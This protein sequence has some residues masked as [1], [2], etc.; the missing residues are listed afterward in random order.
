M[1]GLKINIVISI[2]LLLFI[3][4]LLTTFVITIFWQRDLTYAEVQRLSTVLKFVEQVSDKHETAVLNGFDSGKYNEL[5]GQLNLSCTLLYQN[6]AY[7]SFHEN[8][9][10]ERNTLERLLK[11]AMQSGE[12]EK[13]TVGAIWGVFTPGKRSLLVA[14]P[15]RNEDG[16]VVGSIG[17]VSHLEHLYDSIRKSQ[18]IIFVYIGVNLIILTVVGLFRFIKIAV[19][20]L[21]KLVQLTDSYNEKDGV[22]LFISREG[23]E[24]GQ[25]SG[26]LN[27]MMERIEEDRKEL[28][29]TVDELSSTN[30]KLQE[31]QREMVQAEKLASIGRLAAGLAHEIGNPISIVQGYI[32]LLEQEHLH[33]DERK[34]FGQRAE[35]E[36]QRI[37]ALIRQ[38]LDLARSSGS[39]TPQVV[40]IHELLDAV[41]E[42]FCSQPLMGTIGLS[43]KYMASTDTVWCDP[44]QL[45]Q[46]MLN[47]LINATDAVAEND[48]GKDKNIDIIT[49][50]VQAQS[51]EEK[52]LPKILISIR[53]T[54]VGIPENELSNV[55]DPFYTTKA[56]GKGTG[57]GLSV[58]HTIIESIGGKMWVDSNEGHDTTMQIELPLHNGKKPELLH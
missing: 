37:S 7:S 17:T 2:I 58:S 46:V 31:T 47:C 54:G 35:K 33:G 38:L 1:Q 3:G 41:V 50:I 49:N 34:D 43:K 53:D 12:Q 5:F 20:P 36:L 18:R 13:T 26:A 24:F 10:C 6:G 57:L 4:M 25:L 40:K 15:L 27:R 28:L 14:N 16:V 39:G 32:G 42:M 30:E 21:E 55:F 19:K 23:N 44:D 51:R 8:D 11:K 29:K 9:L 45:R 56:P 22:P 48:A 52:V